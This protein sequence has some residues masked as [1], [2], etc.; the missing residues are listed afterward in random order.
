MKCDDAK[1]D[2]VFIP[3][4]ELDYE[5]KIEVMSHLQEC[6]GCR[7]EYVQYLKTF[8]II[9]RSKVSALKKNI[10]FNVSK[11][12]QLE[13]NRSVLKS[14]MNKRNW[15]MAAI[16]FSIIIAL[17]LIYM[18]VEQKSIEKKYSLKKSIQNEDWDEIYNLLNTAKRVEIKNEKIPVSLI[19]NKLEMY[20]LGTFSYQTIKLNPEKIRQTKKLLKKYQRY[21]KTILVEDI[22]DFYFKEEIIS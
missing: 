10:D 1:K 20:S 19:L 5:R 8:Y 7:L 16:S 4:N 12:I 15:L 22:L 21:Q 13:I 3:R 9:D 11:N 14:K 6:D 17:T 18:P 2:I